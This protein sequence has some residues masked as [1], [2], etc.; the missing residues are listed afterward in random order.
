MGPSFDGTLQAV[1]EP[2]QIYADQS[3]QVLNKSSHT[4]KVILLVRHD[5][6]ETEGQRWLKTSLPVKRKVKKEWKG[7]DRPQSPW[8]CNP[9]DAHCS[10][11]SNQG[12]HPQTCQAVGINMTV[13]MSSKLPLAAISTW[14]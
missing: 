5:R 6:H 10:V 7:E 9:A 3:E 1:Q 14:R 4:G 12:H 8:G 11:L 13:F 2:V